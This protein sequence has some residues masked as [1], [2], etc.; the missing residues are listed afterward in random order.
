MV[1]L[2]LK[3]GGNLGLVYEDKAVAEEVYGEAEAGIASGL[4]A[5]GSHAIVAPEDSDGARATIDPAAIGA[6][7]MMPAPPRTLMAGG[8]PGR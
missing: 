8:R 1:V 6:A 4:A 3:G 7:M 2:M 5:D